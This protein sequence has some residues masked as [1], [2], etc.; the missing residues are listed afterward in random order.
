MADDQSERTAPENGTVADV[1]GK[2]CIYY[3]GYW[4]RYY[5]PPEDRLSER[6][7]LIDTL[8]RRLFHHTEAGINTP[9]ERLD[10][11]RKSFEREQDPV[12]KRVNAAMLAG[13]LFNRAT[14]IFNTV[15]DLAEKGVEISSDNELMRQCERYFE[16]ALELGKQ[17][18]HYSG[19]EGIDEMWGEPFKA[20]VMPTAAFY[21]TRYLKI[22]QSMR[23][24]DAIANV[25]LETCA[26]L[27]DFRGIVPLISHFEVMARLECETMRRDPEIFDVWPAYVAAGEALL[28]FEPANCTQDN[29]DMLRLMREGK[30]LI[31]YV[32]SA[33][34]PMPKST[35]QYLESCQRMRTRLR[36]G[37]LR[38]AAG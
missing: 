34:V 24:M 13:A 23:D 4:I 28:A 14:D 19:H 9:G 38:Q 37:A 30:R 35:E 1:D 6:K 5:E 11:A 17:V 25:M 2:R 10:L 31:G 7:A 15:V 26:L 16:E 27:E 3:D 8:T 20:F 22:A 32:A 36:R 21:E 33:R 12:R 29:A 18:K